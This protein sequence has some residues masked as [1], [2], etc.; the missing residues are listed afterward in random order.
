MAA[1]SSCASRAAADMMLLLNKVLPLLLLP[2]G[3]V[4]G[5][6]LFA[7]W[8]KK[9]W[10]GL[11]ALAVLYLSSIPLVAE[12]LMGWLESR[13]PV[14]PLKKLE[15]VD[16]AIVLGGIVGPQPAVDAQPNWSEAFERF[17]AGVALMQ[18]GRAKHLV[19]SG[20]RMPWDDSATT[21]G[22]ELKQRAIARGVSPERIIIGPLVDNTSGEAQA[23]LGLM[24]ERKWKRVIV[25]TTGWHMPR[26]AL[27]FRRAGVDAVFFPV[28]FRTDP[29]S[30]LTVI[31]FVPTS[32]A[33]QMTETALREGY[34]WLF[35]WLF[36]RGAP[37]Q[38]P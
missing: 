35:Y 27:Q 25:V 32:G 16:A 9:W 2:F 19:F 26:A 36:R 1:G 5:L 24:R 8:R 20:A 23:T 34:G 38:A 15:V 22:D 12:R 18:G 6:V 3:L 31:D 4:C 21:E 29:S 14:I 28:D 7:L 37:A 17:E 10:P 30:P 33:W 13:Y 11:L